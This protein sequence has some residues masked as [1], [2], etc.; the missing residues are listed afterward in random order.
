MQSSATTN[1]DEI[2]EKKK[3]RA[4]RFVCLYFVKYLFF[5]LKNIKY[6]MLNQDEYDNASHTVCTIWN[7]VLV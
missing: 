6:E 3:K 1:V 4:E 7:T 5:I 2:L